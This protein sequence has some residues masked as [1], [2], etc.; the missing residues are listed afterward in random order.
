VRSN[1]QTQWPAFLLAL[2][3]AHCASSTEPASDRPV[4]TTGGGANVTANTDGSGGASA[5]REAGSVTMSIPSTGSAGNSGSTSGAGGMREADGATGSPMDAGGAVHVVS[6]CASL[7][8]KG[9]WQDTTPSE[10]SAKFAKQ[11]YGV[12]AL[13][14]NPKNP[15]VVYFGTHQIGIWKSTD[16]GSSWT[17]INTGENGA[18]LDGGF[19]WSVA[20]D[21]VNPDV[22]YA[23]S[24]YSSSSGAWKSSD[25][26]VNWKPLWPPQDPELAKVVQYNFVHKIR[27]DPFDHRHLLVSFHA[28]CNAPYK[29]ACIAESKDEGSTWKMVNGNAAWSGGEDQTVWFLDNSQTWLY[30]SQSNGMW[31]TSD[32]GATWKVIDSGWGGHNGGQLY[33]SKDGTFYHSGPAGLLRSADGIAWSRMANV[34]SGMIGVTGTGTTLYASHGP[35]AEQPTYLPYYTAS[36]SDGQVWMRLTTPLLSTGGYELAYDP[37]HHLLY[38]TNATAG[39]RRVVVP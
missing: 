2:C 34:G 26:G 5:D 37:D 27:I 31:R 35:Y 8:E 39:F 20:I 17:H 3:A 1:L 29:S 33:R 7:P 21:P 23:N 6:E 25:G 18:V 12:I 32:G 36:E 22:L 10:V 24:G 4:E 38:S 9:M 28:A 13:A 15:A 14:M 30:A 11:Q 19:Q 16:C